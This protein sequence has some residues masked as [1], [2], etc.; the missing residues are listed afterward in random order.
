M[1]PGSTSWNSIMAIPTIG[2]PHDSI[3]TW[4]GRTGHTLVGRKTRLPSCSTTRG[5]PAE[6]GHGE[7]I[8]VHQLQLEAIGAAEERHGEAAGLGWRRAAADL[9]Q[10]LIPVVGGWR[11]CGLGV[12]GSAT[13]A[14]DRITV[15]TRSSA[16]AAHRA[17][18]RPPWSARRGSGLEPP[19]RMRHRRS[20]GRAPAAPR[21]FVSCAPATPFQMH[22]CDRPAPPLQRNL[23]LIGQA[24]SSGPAPA[25][26]PGAWRIASAV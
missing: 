16:P 17:R 18:L 23:R 19:T 26:K 21:L 10:V 1:S 9:T 11:A 5:S 12:G 8:A 13:R 25:P 3:P 6:T 20:Q 2:S 15:R 7:P 14:D 24:W 4:P 22:G